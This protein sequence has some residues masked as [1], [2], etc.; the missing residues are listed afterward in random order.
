VLALVRDGLRYGSRNKSRL[1]RRFLEQ[2][3][4]RY[5]TRDQ[6]V[7]NKA[8]VKIRVS[9]VDVSAFF[10]VEAWLLLWMK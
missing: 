9:E 8:R 7:N 6:K 2:D 4:G 3:K 5:D 10:D 1:Y